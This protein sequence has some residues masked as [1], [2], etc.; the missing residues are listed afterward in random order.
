MREIEI[1]RKNERAGGG[2]ERE[3]VHRGMRASIDS[4]RACD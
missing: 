2:G 1:E 4:G 3:E